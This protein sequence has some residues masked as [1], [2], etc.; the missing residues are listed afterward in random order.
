M[1]PSAAT[2]GG[3][4]DPS[5]RG[6]TV[7]TWVHPGMNRVPARAGQARTQLGATISALGFRP[8]S[9]M[10]KV[11]DMAALGLLL[12]AA[13]GVTALDGFLANDGGDHQITNFDV[14]GLHFSGSSGLLFRT[15][16]S[17]APSPSSA[18]SFCLRGGDAGSGRGSSAGGSCAATGGRPTPCTRNVTSW[19]SSW[20]VS[21]ASVSVRPWPGW[22]RV[23]HP[24]MHPGRR[25]PSRRLPRQP[26]LRQLPPCRPPPCRPPPCR[27][28]TTGAGSAR[29]E[30]QRG[31][32]V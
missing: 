22:P 1:T 2:L 20:R 24:S 18:W 30:D 14:F 6:R 10:G 4:A 25:R 5:D 19:P 11:T 26:P 12:L 17:S 3:P 9:A 16:P 8:A 15:G 21:V 28:S 27:L 31:R 7:R 29:A 23:R 13:A 32:Q